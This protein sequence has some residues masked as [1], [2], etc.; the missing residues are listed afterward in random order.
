MV[1]QTLLGP[2]PKS[3]DSGRYTPHKPQKMLQK[4]C[5]LPKIEGPAPHLDIFDTCQKI[6]LE[7]IKITQNIYSFCKKQF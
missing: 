1:V 5:S 6:L 7:N 2:G 3:F 4:I